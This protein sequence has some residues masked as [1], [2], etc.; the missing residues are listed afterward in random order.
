MARSFYC[1]LLRLPLAILSATLAACGVVDYFVGNN[2]NI[3]GAA[4]LLSSENAPPGRNPVL[5]LVAGNSNA[6][7]QVDLASLLSGGA[8]PAICNSKKEWYEPLFTFKPP[9]DCL[10]DALKAFR[11]PPTNAAD[12][13]DY[14]SSR[15][16]YLRNKRNGIQDTLMTVSESACRQFT[17]HLNSYQAYTNLFFGALATSAGAAG[18]IVTNEAAA[19]A[20]AGSAGGLTGIRAEY[21]ND[22][23]YQKA[24]P[25]ITKAIT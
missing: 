1:V 4:P 24:V 22:I 11:D 13:A 8:L 15:N 16:E 7:A 2:A 12:L 20:L 19:R 10:A 9:Q 3:N 21:N 6:F 23:F 25:I 17:Q 14:T 18:A 5:G